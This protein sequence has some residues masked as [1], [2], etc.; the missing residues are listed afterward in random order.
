MKVIKWSDTIFFDDGADEQIC[1]L[2]GEYC[3][4]YC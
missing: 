4:G 2:C 1:P 3:C